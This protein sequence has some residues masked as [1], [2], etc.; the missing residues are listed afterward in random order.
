VCA[1]AITREEALRRK[2]MIHQQNEPKWAMLRR[3]Q[4][5]PARATHENEQRNTCHGT[6]FQ[7][8]K[9]EKSTLLAYQPL[10]AHH[11]RLLL[12]ASHRKKP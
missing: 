7:I 11:R 9:V 8:V 5:K 3:H 1:N 4:Q 6:L 10:V 12:I 2:V